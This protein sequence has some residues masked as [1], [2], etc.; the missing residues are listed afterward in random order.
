MILNLR[1]A[2]KP[3]TNNFTNADAIETIQFQNMHSNLRST[4]RS[5]VTHSHNQT[6]VI[7]EAH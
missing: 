6:R 1:S 7:E 2:G 5:S 4:G 3:A